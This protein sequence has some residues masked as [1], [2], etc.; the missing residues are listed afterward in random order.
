MLLGLCYTDLFILTHGC[1]CKH[2]INGDN[3]DDIIIGGITVFDAANEALLN[4]MAKWS[5][6]YSYN[7]RIAL[8]FNGSR[9]NNEILLNNS[10]VFDDDVRETLYGKKGRD[11]FLANDVYDYIK[12]LISNEILT[13][14]NIT[15]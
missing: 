10:T 9:L 3:G 5:A 1:M 12:D 7:E 15:L 13:L 11:W 4:I 6:D 8:L 14:I 2:K